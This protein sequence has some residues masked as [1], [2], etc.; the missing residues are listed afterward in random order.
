MK[1]QW[2]NKLS[3]RERQIMD[4][5]YEKGSVTVAEVHENMVDPPSYSAVRAL[6]NILEK[7]GVISHTEQGPRYVYSPVVSRQNAR[8]GAL[9]HVMKTFFDNSAEQVVAA[10]LDIRGQELDDKEIER[11]SRLIEAARQE[12]NHDVH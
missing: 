1:K 4:V 2:M 11:L 12:E 10:L 7:K 5:I 3:R 6:M 9:Q 8:R